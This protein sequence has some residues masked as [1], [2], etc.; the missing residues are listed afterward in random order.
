MT[1]PDKPSQV[2]GVSV[3]GWIALLL[4]ATL[5]VV[6][7]LAG[8]TFEVFGITVGIVPEVTA[9]IIDTFSNATLLALGFYFGQKGKQ[10]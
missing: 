9:R 2:A 7:L 10:E 1:E 5:C 8:M 4:I 6:A 3:R